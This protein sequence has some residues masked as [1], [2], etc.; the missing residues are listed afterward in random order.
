MIIVFE[1]TFMSS[2]L[3]LCLA[4]YCYSGGGVEISGMFLIFGPGD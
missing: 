2:G 1:D 4:S 3:I